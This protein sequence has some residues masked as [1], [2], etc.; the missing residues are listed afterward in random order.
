MKRPNP[1]MI[2]LLTLIAMVATVY[3]IAVLNAVPHHPDLD[4]Y[5]RGTRDLAQG[6]PLYD[7]FLNASGDPALRYAF[8][9]PPLF[10]ILM[11][12]FLV[13]PTTV[14]PIVWLIATHAALGVTFFTV[15]GRLRTNRMVVLLSLLITLAFYPL[16][17][18]ASQAQANLPI[19]L[20]V[21]L[22]MVGISDGKPRAGIWI[23]LAAA[24][25]LT[26]GLL[27][28]W[29]LLERRFRAA[30]WTVAA[31][32]GV[33]VLA[34]LIR[35]TDSLTYARYVIPQLAGGTAY[36]SN[37]SIDGVASR[38]LTT[39]R[40]TTPLLDLSWAHVLV[41][42]LAIAALALW[43][44]AGRRQVEPLTRAIAFLPLVPLFSAVSW[45]HHL[46]IL[47]PLVWLILTVLADRGWPVRETAVAGLVIVTLLAIP[48]LPFGPPYATDFARAAHTHN[49]LVLVG[50]NRLFVG[51]A[52]LLV[53]SPWLLSRAGA[54]G[55]HSRRLSTAPD[56]VLPPAAAA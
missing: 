15:L 10:A 35:P 34:A 2:A 49:P 53:V 28:V 1:P 38:L 11:L 16:W 40:Y 17:V 6:R 46:V 18:D 43:V 12:P 7:A 21:M 30:G 48:H 20:L 37:Q 47:L 31:F 27:L 8:I 22:G 55:W 44:S 52:L 45:E 26:P 54:G 56:R 23:G 29:L 36:W 50:A 19:L 42:S 13:V 3:A 4:V 24:L 5:L 51:T 9:Y 41:V 33:T 32:V 14:L 25:K 39:N